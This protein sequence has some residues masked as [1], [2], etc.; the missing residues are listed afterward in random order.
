MQYVHLW[1]GDGKAVQGVE[2][3]ADWVTKL[4]PCEVLVE[5]GCARLLDAVATLCPALHSRGRC[6]WLGENC[7]YAVRVRT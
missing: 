3:P 5:A 1:V 4:A 7:S 6:T 2:E